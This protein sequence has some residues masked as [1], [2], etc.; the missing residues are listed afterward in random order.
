MAYVAADIALT[1]LVLFILSLFATAL[2][3]AP[4]V[5]RLV[6][7]WKLNQRRQFKNLQDEVLLHELESVTDETTRQAMR[8][9]L[10]ARQK[11]LQ[12]RVEALDSKK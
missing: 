1:L 9:E 4:S 7:R 11:S 5:L 6:R 12:A 10:I 2:F 8:E 3:G